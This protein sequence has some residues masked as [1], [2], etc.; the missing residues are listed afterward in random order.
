MKVLGQRKNEEV[1]NYDYIGAMN[2]AYYCHPSGTKLLEIG[3]TSVTPQITG[4]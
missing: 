1:K 2:V 3:D 4:N